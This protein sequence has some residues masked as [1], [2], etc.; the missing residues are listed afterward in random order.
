MLLISL[1][2]HNPDTQSASLRV[3]IDK[4][5]LSAGAHGQVT[6]SWI[7]KESRSDC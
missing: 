5:N 2:R 3:T 4:E 7:R 6:G 1:P